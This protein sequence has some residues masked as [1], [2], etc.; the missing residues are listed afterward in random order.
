MAQPEL[1]DSARAAISDVLH[2]YAYL[3]REKGDV[4]AIGRL[5]TAD[6]VFVLP[7]GNAVPIAGMAAIVADNPPVFIRHH[8]TT[9]VVDFDDEE[10]ATAISYFVAY[11]HL[12]QPDHWGYWRDSLRKIDGRWLLT[13]KQPVVEGYAPDGD[14]AKMPWNQ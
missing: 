1:I 11:T 5:F 8:L 6:G 2:R 10:N 14:W 12:A 9:S 7:D 13:S 4:D 3:A